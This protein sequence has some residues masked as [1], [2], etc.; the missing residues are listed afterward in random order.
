MNIT[1]LL[2]FHS[3]GGPLC[4]TRSRSHDLLSSLHTALISLCLSFLLFLSPFPV[5]L[6]LKVEAIFY[7]I[8][9]IPGTS[10][11]SFLFSNLEMRKLHLII[12]NLPKCRSDQNEKPAF[13]SPCTGPLH[14]QDIT[15]SFLKHSRFSFFKH[16]MH[17]EKELYDLI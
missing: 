11:C 12:F 3:W 5:F 10:W 9:Y 8:Q 2:P 4:L 15:V 14:Q 1:V 6:Y 16:V 7:H 13:V 17:H